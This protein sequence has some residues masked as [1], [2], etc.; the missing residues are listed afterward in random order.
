MHDPR[1][2]IP[3]QGWKLHV[4]A[5]PGTLA[6]TLDRVLPVLFGTACDFKVARSA[7]VLA[8]LNSGDG[9]A[10]AVGKAVT[11][12]PAPDEAAALGHA[13]AEALAGMAGPRIVSDRRV[14][15]DAPVYYRYAPFLPQYKVDENGDF[16]LVV[17]GPDGET[18][19]GAAGNEYTCPPWA[20]D[21]FR[22]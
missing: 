21:P 8:D 10:G 5:R 3:A 18:L 19:P 7:A 14:R 6:E 1:F 17:V 9:D 2:E 12:Y 4:S 13:L 20:S 11:V 22:P 16:S 15:R